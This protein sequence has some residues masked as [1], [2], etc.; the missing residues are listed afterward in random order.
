MF[1][2]SLVGRFTAEWL[3]D[4]MTTTLNFWECFDHFFEHVSDPTQDG[5]AIRDV[6]TSQ[7]IKRAVAV[8]TGSCGSAGSGP[9]GVSP[10]RL[11]W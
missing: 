4:L 9:V 5:A 11:G 8:S 2:A 3:E 1:S 6:S 7:G 10:A